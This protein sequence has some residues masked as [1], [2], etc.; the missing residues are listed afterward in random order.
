MPI[1]YLLLALIPGQIRH[2]NVTRYYADST[3]PRPQSKYIH[4]AHEP[5]FG[6]F[7]CD[8]MFEII[9]PSI[10]ATD[11]TQSFASRTLF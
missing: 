10:G 11:N 7:G 9:A 1:E 4:D 3:T 6:C 2:V 5:R 8:A